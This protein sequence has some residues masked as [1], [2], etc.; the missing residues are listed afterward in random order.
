MTA[1]F[2]PY[3]DYQKKTGGREIPIVVLD[4]VPVR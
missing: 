3:A 1:L 4:P 2:A